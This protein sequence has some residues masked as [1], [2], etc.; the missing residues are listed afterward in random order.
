MIVG[1][2]TG[3]G[4][5]AKEEEK[6]QFI[7]HMLCQWVDMQGQ[8]SCLRKSGIFSIK[9]DDFK[10]SKFPYESANEAHLNYPR[11]ELISIVL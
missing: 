10:D 6:H 5:F 11:K 2:L 9:P 7:V 1:L 4:G 3:H 8:G